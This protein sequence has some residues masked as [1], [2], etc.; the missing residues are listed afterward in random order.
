MARLTAATDQ[1]LFVICVAGCASTS[2][3]GGAAAGAFGSGGLPG[4][5]AAGSGGEPANASGAS[6]TPGPG[7]GDAGAAGQAA[8]SGSHSLFNGADFTGW[9][10]YL[11]KPSAAEPALGIDND[12]RAVYS[13]VSLDGEPAI[14]ISG[15]IWGSLI[16]QRQFC[17]FRLHAEFKWGK[18]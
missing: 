18:A 5:S 11:G 16:S 12:P 15:E 14:R 1:L 3:H 17:N 6:N 2:T 9:D 8:N 4:A 10:R 13:I 7:A